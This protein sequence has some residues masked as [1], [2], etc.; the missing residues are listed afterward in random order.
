MEINGLRLNVGLF[1]N[2]PMAGAPPARNILMARTNKIKEIT[3]KTQ[4]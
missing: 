3:A 1:F 4:I 2:P